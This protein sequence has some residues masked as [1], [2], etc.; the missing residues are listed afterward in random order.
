MAGIERDAAVV[1]RGKAA[2]DPDHV[3]VSG[4]PDHGLGYAPQR[5][6]GCD[7]ALA[8]PCAIVRLPG[9]LHEV[10]V[11][12][13]DQLVLILRVVVDHGEV[14]KVYGNQDGGRSELGWL[15]FEPLLQRVASEGHVLEAGIE[16]IQ[17]DD[18]DGRTRRKVLEV[19]GGVDRDLRRRNE[20]SGRIEVANH[21]RRVGF[22]DVKLFLLHVRDDVALLVEH[23]AVQHDHTDVARD[24]V[25]W[26]LGLR[27]LRGGLRLL[28]AYV[29]GEEQDERKAQ[30]KSTHGWTPK[31]SGRD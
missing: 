19:G 16:L 29:D 6:Q 12:C 26:G 11:E 15:G 18:V 1:E 24:G 23:D 14:L 8:G 5:E 9:I 2:T 27:G 20:D 25:G 13:L 31:T 17:Q 28:R 30:G 3:L 22:S 4:V 7:V 21:L 10:L